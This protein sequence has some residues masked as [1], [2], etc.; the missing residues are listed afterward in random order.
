MSSKNNVGQIKELL[1]KENATLE[2]TSEYIDRRAK[3]LNYT[4][5]FGESHTTSLADWQRGRRCACY[6][7]Y[8]KCKCNY[9]NASLL[10]E[11][12]N[13]KL[14]STLEECSTVT[15]PLVFINSSGEEQKISLNNLNLCDRFSGHKE[16]V[17][18]LTNENKKQIDIAEELGT[19]QHIISMC[20]RL[21]GYNNSNGNRFIEIDI[22]KEILQ[23]L[24]W[25]EERHPKYIADKYNCSITT[26]V[27]NMKKYNIPLRSK[28]EARQGKLNPIF[29]VGHTDAAKKKMSAAFL[30]GRD[31][32]YSGNW[33]KISKYFSPLQGMLTMRSSWESR[34]ADYLTAN[35]EPWLYEP[36]TFKLSD[37]ISYKPDFYLISRD[38]Y[39]EVKGRTLQED[40]YKPMKLR[41]M[42]VNIIILD[43]GALELLN[44][45]NSSGK[46]IYNK[47]IY[48]INKFIES[49][50]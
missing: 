44:L 16:K 28:S 20:L 5:K 37:L 7:K 40:L 29:D 47:E 48:S 21:W 1:K 27:K 18:S 19:T 43:R 13:A 24:Y 32:G 42:G 11:K 6:N 23:Q 10:L 39:V 38:L 41:D 49:G 22:P 12:Y 15:T 4:C 36:T 26:V 35:A 45:I 8:D 25:V 14:L 50:L 30:N 31:R 9:N 34:V 17:I 2:E 33:G 3:T 46:P